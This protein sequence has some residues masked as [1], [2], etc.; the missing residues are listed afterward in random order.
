MDTRVN[1]E[2]GG[3]AIWTEAPLTSLFLNKTKT[4]T[5]REKEMWDP[6]RLNHF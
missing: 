2:G 1:M 4:K 5:E 3:G 6:K